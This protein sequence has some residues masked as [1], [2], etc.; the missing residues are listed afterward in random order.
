MGIDHLA[1]L[2]PLKQFMPV[3]GQRVVLLSPGCVRVAQ[4][5]APSCWPE[6]VGL[7]QTPK[8]R[9]GYSQACVVA[10]PEDLDSPSILA[11]CRA[12]HEVWILEDDPCSVAQQLLAFR[13]QSAPLTLNENKSIL[14]A[15]EVGVVRVWRVNPEGIVGLRVAQPVEENSQLSTGHL[16]QVHELLASQSGNCPADWMNMA[17]LL[18]EHARDRRKLVR[19]SLTGL[20]SLTILG[21]IGLQW[22]SMSSLGIPMGDLYAVFYLLVGSVYLWGKRQQWNTEQLAWMSLAE[23]LDSQALLGRA[24]FRQGAITGLFLLRH[25]RSVEWIR[26]ALRPMTWALHSYVS[27]PTASSY[28]LLC[29]WVPHAL[30]RH[31]VMAQRQ[32]RKAWALEWGMRLCYGIGGILTLVAISSFVQAPWSSL[33]VS[34]GIGMTSSLGTLMLIFNG[35]LG[36]AEDADLHDHLAGVFQHAQSCLGQQ[37]SHHEYDELLMD[38]VQ[39]GVQQSAERVLL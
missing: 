32:R 13:T 39:E 6:L 15:P 25:R 21:V 2:I 27:P 29:D 7:L 3:P 12:A 36:F 18:R 38:L 20:F 9:C 33:V 23:A 19:W 14:H 35:V 16:A 1:G 8:G 5:Q 31:R 17:N 28:Q 4:A 10:V 37:M 22:L 11:L 34:I 26:E 24:G 30:N